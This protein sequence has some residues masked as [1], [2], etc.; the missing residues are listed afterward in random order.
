[1][2]NL[3]PPNDKRQMH[4]GQSN[5]LLL[6][7]CIASLLLAI[8]LFGLVGGVYFI[9]RNSEN[10]ARAAIEESDRKSSG[11]QETEKNAAEFRKNLQIAKGI[12]DK[13]VRY[14]KIAVK[15]AQTMPSG[16]VLESLELDASTFGQSVTLNALG[17]SYDDAIRLKTAFERSNDFNDAHL[18]V[19]SRGE[20]DEQGFNTSISI[21]VIISPDIVRL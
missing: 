10:T 5:V 2:I 13:E 15:V 1:M 4:A 12:L 3:L 17:K 11:Y 20:T 9:M 19:V 16:I 18:E 21:S 6:R 14:S 7:Y 8:P